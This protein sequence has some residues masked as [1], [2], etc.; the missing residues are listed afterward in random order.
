MTPSGMDHLNKIWLHK[1]S[2]LWP[3]PE[4]FNL[5]EKVLQFGTGVLLR[6]LPD[7][8]I[9]RANQQ[10]LFNGRIAIIKS[11]TGG[12]LNGFQ[13]QDGLYT[14]CVRGIKAG[15]KVHENRICGAIS[16]VLSARD[17][18]PDILAAALQPSLE[19]IISNTTEV[20]LTLVLEDIRLTPP[21]SF[22]GKLTA[23]LYHRWKNKGSGLII[24]PTELV[25]DNGTKLYELVRQVSKH[26]H[27]ED[28]F[29]TW[30]K[31]ECTF[32]NSLVDRIVPGHPQ[33]KE[34]AQLFDELGY[35]DKLAILAEDYR[36]WAIEGDEKVRRV[37]SFV[38]GDPGVIISPDITKYR[39]LKLRLLNGT[40]TFACGIACLAGIETVRAGMEHKDLAPFIKQLILQDI[41]QAMAD[42]IP[43]SEIQAFG[44]QVL[45]RFLN[46]YV[47]HLW[48]N[49]TLQYTSKMRLRNLPLLMSYHRRHG[50]FPASFALG[51]AAFLR[52]MRVDRVEEDRFYG[53][54]NGAF[55]LIRDDQAPYFMQ[56]NQKARSPQELIHLVLENSTLWGEPIRI[57]GLLEKVRQYLT[58]INGEGML[59]TLEKHNI[60]SGNQVAS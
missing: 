16:R 35:T 24:I 37:L 5:P 29:V 51:M 44:A 14:L 28:K 17:H 34:E 30:L 1:Q 7:Y 31:E 46:P 10:G 20:G 2:P 57:P 40:H 53:Q 32:C 56:I 23:L 3:S 58:Q 39:E 52:F 49:I 36:L 6:G 19:L 42:D 11:T 27:L 41:A 55:Y 43:Q 15:A 33:G 54:F 47:R 50:T 25:T 22:P 59:K 38:G 18:W 21:T 13:E 48:I 12:E 8:F 9:D 45:D 26:N 60:A 4:V